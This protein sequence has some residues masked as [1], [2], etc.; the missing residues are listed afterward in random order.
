MMERPTPRS[1]PHSADS[2]RSPGPGS[3]TIRASVPHLA[4]LA[5]R[6]PEL[7]ARDTYAQ[8]LRAFVDGLLLHVQE[9]G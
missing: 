2:L 4:A 1:H 9:V 5:D 6:W 7:T 3:P 8:G